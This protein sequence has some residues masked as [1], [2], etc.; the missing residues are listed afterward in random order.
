MFFKSS[1]CEKL[2]NV[3]VAFKT[4]DIVGPA[5]IIRDPVVAAAAFANTNDNTAPVSW[6]K[7]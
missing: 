6:K 2:L 5:Q 3:G 4:T 7:H 1:S